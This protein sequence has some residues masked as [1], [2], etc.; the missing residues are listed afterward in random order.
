M[1]KKVNKV[2]WHGPTATVSCTDG[3]VYSC[4]HLL[5]T[6]SVGV[7]K[8]LC[9]NFEPTLPE[10]KQDVIKRLPMGAT[11]KIFLKFPQKW[12]VDDF[13][14]L[15]F[16]WNDED[17]KWASKEFSNEPTDNGRF[18]V[19][20]IF[21]FFVLDYF[22]TVLIVWIGGPM[23]KQIENLSDQIVVNGCLRVLK[24][25]LKEKYDG[26]KPEETIRYILPMLSFFF[27][28]FFFSFG[29]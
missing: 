18:W 7:L 12:W 10:K 1:N 6:V 24:H 20:D 22:P 27:F 11:H 8:H 13:N 19:E 9:S 28:K 16:L 15:S 5:L 21:G 3:S 17:R 2:V 29:F 14:G 26:T 25:F 23:V 4:D